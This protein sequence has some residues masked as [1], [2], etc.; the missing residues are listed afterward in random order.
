[1]GWR[2]SRPF[3]RGLVIGKFAPLHRG[4]E[5]LIEAALSEC[6]TVSVWC[7]S[8]PDFP[9]MPTEV[10]RSWIR[11][12]FPGVTAL[13]DAL[14]PPPNDAPDEVHQGY[15]RH[16]LSEWN[17]RPDAVFT[18]EAYGESLARTLGCEHRM[19]DAAR[20]RAPMSGTRV[21]ADVHAH[22]A[23]LSPLV[24]A[25]FVEKVVLLGAESTGKSTLTALLAREF[26][27]LGV[28]EYGRD[29]F[30]RENGRLRPEHFVEIARGHRALEE[31]ALLSAAVYRFLFVDTNA[32]TTA[33][34]SFWLTRT[35][36]PEV[37]RLAAECEGRYR[38]VFVCADDIA[39]EQD[40]WRSNTSVRSV[41][42]ASILYDLAARG[43][44]Y[45]VLHGSLEERC[46]QVRVALAGTNVHRAI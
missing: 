11:A 42:Q 8:N 26:G 34:W 5:L 31:A 12:L 1:M 25:H 9:D 33:M 15:V 6:E 23:F 10:R 18:S 40:G 13:P 41:Q 35:C 38:H 19:V 7:Y 2:V 29:V 22:K 46:A 39:F 14:N 24:Y 28:Q 16:V 3:E 27:T 37:L 20:T 45:T 43:L 4:H 21:R 17:V 44:A 32:I 30:E 36:E